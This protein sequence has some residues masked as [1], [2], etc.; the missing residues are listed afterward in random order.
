M[1]TYI[2]MSYIYSSHEPDYLGD[3]RHLLA[4]FLPPQKKGLVVVSL[5]DGEEEV[6]H[7]VCVCVCARA[8]VRVCVRL[9]PFN[10]SK[11]TKTKKS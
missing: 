3:S 11:C 10:Q 9:C 1:Y 2:Y 4:C 6:C 5:L 7:A 8:C